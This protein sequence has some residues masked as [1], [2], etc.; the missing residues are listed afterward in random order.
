MGG[1][2]QA[3]SRCGHVLQDFVGDQIM[4]PEGQDRGIAAWTEG[5]RV[6]AN[7]NAT[8][9]IPNSEPLEDDETEC[10]ATS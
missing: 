1:L 2:Y 6:A 4:V 10:R 7:D 3:C 5:N 8:W 9:N